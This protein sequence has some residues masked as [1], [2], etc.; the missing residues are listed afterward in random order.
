MIQTSYR[1]LRVAVQSVGPWK[2]TMNPTPTYTLLQQR[3]IVGV[4]CPSN[5]CG[6]IRMGTG[7][8]GNV[9]VMCPIDDDN[10]NKTGI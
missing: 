5:K 9:S 10:N 1:G 6:D 7:L 4:L 3:M 8:Y 2:G